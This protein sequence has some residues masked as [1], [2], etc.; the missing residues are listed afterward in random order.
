MA[1]VKRPL[2]ERLME[3]VQVTDGCWLWQASLDQHGYG[4]IKVDGR[5]MHAH[6]VMYAA[7]FGDVLPGVHICHTCDNPR[8]VNPGHLFPGTDYD[9][10]LDRG[11]K[12]RTA[13]GIHNGRAKLSEAD[14]RAI[15]ECLAH[16]Q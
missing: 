6:R 14:V 7:H 9:N 8:C 11:R 3:K 1:R 16:G 4:E 12:G 15:R 2:M 10:H 5:S 13:K